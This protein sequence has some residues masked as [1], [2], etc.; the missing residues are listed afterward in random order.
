MMEPSRYLNH[1]ALTSA[2]NLYDENFASWLLGRRHRYF[3]YP[4][5]TRGFRGGFEFL[6]TPPCHDRELRRGNRP[7]PSNRKHLLP[8]NRPGALDRPHALERRFWRREVRGSGPR[9]SF[10]NQ[11]RNPFYNGFQEPGREV[12]FGPYRRGRCDRRWHRNTLRIFRSAHEDATRAWYLAGLL[13]SGAKA[14]GRV[15]RQHRNRCH[16]IL[17][18]LHVLLPGRRTCLV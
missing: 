4:S 14:S 9:R 18:P 2:R 8:S 11:G 6:R 7:K 3:E 13:A 12:D 16:R 10:Q 17:W 1:A 5:C 15:R